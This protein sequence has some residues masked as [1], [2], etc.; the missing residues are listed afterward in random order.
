MA[1]DKFCKVCNKKIKSPYTN[2]SY[3]T[4]EPRIVCDN[5]K[6]IHPIVNRFRMQAKLTLKNG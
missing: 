6:E 2:W 4:G 1:K 5:C 3:L